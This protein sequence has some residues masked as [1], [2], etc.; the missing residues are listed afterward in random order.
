M[1]AL[2]I[3]AGSLFAA[4]VLTGCD[5]AF[6]DVA[7]WIA[8]S[9]TL[10]R[11]F[12]QRLDD[13]AEC[14]EEDNCDAELDP[15]ESAFAMCSWVASRGELAPRDFEAAEWERFDRLCKGL[16]D[17]LTLPKGEALRRIE[18]LQAETDRISAAIR[19]DI[20]PREREEAERGNG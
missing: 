12:D 20:E 9:E 6:P 8:D 18:E 16:E 14:V 19:A 3:V 11:R 2:L 7:D 10:A 17:V 15:E 13:L 1:R 5:K 4:L